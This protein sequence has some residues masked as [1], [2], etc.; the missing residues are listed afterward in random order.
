MGSKIGCHSLNWAVENV[1][2]CELALLLRIFKSSFSDFTMFSQNT[3]HEVASYLGGSCFVGFRLATL[4]ENKASYDLKD[5]KLAQIF[6]SLS[7][8]PDF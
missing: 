2:L 3:K 4:G 1:Y 7:P 8:G 6:P 5:C